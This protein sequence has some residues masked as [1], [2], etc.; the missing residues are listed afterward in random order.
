MSNGIGGSGGGGG[1]SSQELFGQMKT[2]TEEKNKD[3]LEMAKLDK[4]AS[5]ASKWGQIINKVQ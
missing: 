1:I 2:L 5:I 3:T 4:D